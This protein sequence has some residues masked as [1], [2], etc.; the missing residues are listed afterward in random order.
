MNGLQTV[1]PV[2]RL[3]LVAALVLMLGGGCRVPPPDLTPLPCNHR[4]CSNELRCPY[5]QPGESCDCANNCM[6]AGNASGQ[7]EWCCMPSVDMAAAVD[8]AE[9]DAAPS[10]GATD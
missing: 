9:P 7:L 10:D 2:I 8:A 3:A 1:A 5:E 4:L 6:G